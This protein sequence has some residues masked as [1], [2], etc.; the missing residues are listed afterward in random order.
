MS[1]GKSN[2]CSAAFPVLRR[3]QSGLAKSSPDACNF[4][5][6]RTVSLPRQ[7]VCLG[8]STKITEE[9]RLDGV[10]RE[11]TGTAFG[12]RVWNCAS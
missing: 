10:S 9:I 1:E 2:I 11:L 5:F 7:I 3:K 12:P 4:G 8:S 6:F